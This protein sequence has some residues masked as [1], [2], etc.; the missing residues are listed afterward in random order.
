V[1]VVPYTR[2]RSVEE[3]DDR[4]WQPIGPVAVGASLDTAV[5]ANEE[6]KEAANLAIILRGIGGPLILR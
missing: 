5:F 4:C 6:L 3:T 2:P 1:P